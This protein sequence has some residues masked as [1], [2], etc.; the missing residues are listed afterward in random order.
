MIA[1]VLVFYLGATAYWGDPPTWFGHS[2]SG[3]TIAIVMVVLAIA[4]ILSYRTA[5]GAK[6]PGAPIV[7][8]LVLAG[9]TLVLGMASYARCD[10]ASHPTF[11]TALR[12]TAALFTG[13]TGDPD[14]NA[15]CVSK[16]TPPVA[17]DVARLSAFGLLSISAVLVATGL[18]QDRLDRLRVASARSVTAIVEIDDDAQP[19]VSTIRRAM[20]NETSRSVATRIKNVLRDRRVLV[21]ITDNP[22]RACVVE[23]RNHG[24]RIVTVDFHRAETVTSLTLWAKLDRPYLLSPD[25][26]ANLL[27]LRMIGANTKVPKDERLPV[28]VRIDDPWQAEAW[29]AQRFT[30]KERQWA[31]NAIGKYE[32]TARRLIDD[33]VSGRGKPIEKFFICDTSPLTLALCAEL[34]Q[35]QHERDLFTAEGDSP[36]PSA[37][38]VGERAEEY[39]EDHDDHQSRRGA[40]KN[41]VTIDAEQQ[42]PSA[43]ALSR[44]I[45]GSRIDPSAIAV[46]LVDPDPILGATVDSTTG[47]RLAA[48]YPKMPVYTWDPHARADDLDP[49]VG[50]VRT[51]RLTLD[52]AQDRL[53][54]A[55][56]LIHTR[57]IAENKSDLP[58]WQNANEFLRGSNPR[59][60]RNALRIVEEYGGDRWNTWDADPAL[61][62]GN[63]HGLAPLEQLRRLGF[64]RD[65]AMAMAQAEHKD[66]C[67]YHRAAGWRYASVRNDEKKRHNK[68]VDWSESNSEICT[69]TLRSLA[70]TLSQ[71]CVLGYRS[72][73][74]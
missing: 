29:P 26:S 44:L 49:I 71:L 11:F 8:V 23:S 48:R 13:E 35:R 52:R 72:R 45:D 38:I 62:V 67:R 46:I 39:P 43:A 57:Y 14:I 65:A 25:S 19:M 74:L 61:P 1:A 63:L 5:G 56:E 58:A 7:A 47:T 68:L 17:L 34:A 37:T 2:D 69:A 12:L 18:F 66:W 33:I 36:L 59:T 6:R 70:T 15:Q 9:T 54:R 21:L 30:G 4:V 20:A 28:T 16:S 50:Q 73:P 40:A 60:V 55:A 42:A 64:D 53:D 22:E 41:G 31:A 32:A 10:D 3:W 24:A 27:R 51:Y